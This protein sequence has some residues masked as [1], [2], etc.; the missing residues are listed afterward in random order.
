MNEYHAAEAVE[1]GKVEDVVLGTKNFVGL[2]STPNP[3]FD[4]FYE[5]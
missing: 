2:E 3:P 1:I 5:E 4:R